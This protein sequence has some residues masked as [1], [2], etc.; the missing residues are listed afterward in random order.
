MFEAG[1][2]VGIENGRLCPFHYFGVPDDVDYANIPWRSAKFDP[3]ALEAAVATEARA[4]NALEQ[5]QAKGGRRCI[6]FCCSQRHA[7]FMA[8]FFHPGRLRAVAVHAGPNSAP[9]TTSLKQLADGEIDVIF[10][11]DMFNEGVDVPAID[12]VMMLRPTEST[13]IWM[14]QLGR[15]LRV[16]DDKERLTVIDYIGN[17]RAFLM[18]LRALAALMNREAESKGRLREMLEEIR[19]GDDLTA[20]WL[21]D[22]L[23]SRRRRYPAALLRPAGTETALES[24]Y[25]DFEE[26]HGV[27]PNAVEVFHAGLNP[28]KQ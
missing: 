1:I 14:Q 18:K 4:R 22:H 25:R 20:A 9:R 24:F 3:E 5:L 17:H 6:G 15:G 2:H 19:Q 7:D 10:A 23:R 16:A 8:A 11:V 28:A 21:R 27:R 12:T 26:R 13:V